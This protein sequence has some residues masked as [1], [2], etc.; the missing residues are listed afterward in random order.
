V[1]L[2]PL[3]IVVFLAVFINPYL[4]LPLLVIFPQLFEG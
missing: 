3:I 4:L 1:T 2:F